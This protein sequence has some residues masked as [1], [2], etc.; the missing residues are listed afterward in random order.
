MAR[1]RSSSEAVTRSRVSVLRGTP[2]AGAVV[3]RTLAPLERSLQAG[4]RKAAQ[5]WRVAQSKIDALQAPL[6]R[7]VGEEPNYKRLARQQ[8]VPVAKPPRY[9]RHS[10]APRVEALTAFSAVPPYTFDWTWHS[11]N[12][13]SHGVPSVNKSTGQFGGHADNVANCGSGVG[14][15]YRP[16]AADVLVQCGSVIKYGIYYVANSHF[17]TAHTEASLNVLVTSTDLAGGDARTIVDNRT[18]IFNVTSN[19]LTQQ[20]YGPVDNLEFR[21]S[22]Q[23]RAQNQRNYLVWTWCEIHTWGNDAATPNW[24]QG[25]GNLWATALNIAIWY[26]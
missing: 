8:R 9:Y 22:V 18:P 17:M 1:K 12:P 5:E 19:Q 16:Q 10:T 23:F 2:L 21:P 13:G 6:V 4:A 26:S 20:V 11:E 15:L 14:V 24:S 7:L 25:Y 3:R